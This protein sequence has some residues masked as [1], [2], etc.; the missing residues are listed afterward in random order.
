MRKG[1]K[2]LGVTL[3]AAALLSVSLIVIAQESVA[4]SPQTLNLDQFAGSEITVHAAI[5]YDAAA[6]VTLASED[7]GT[8]DA[9]VTFADDRGDLVAKFSLEDVKE[10]V[11][12][13][14]NTLA[15]LVDGRD[16]GSDTI[17]VILGGKQKG[18]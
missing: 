5:D 1:L 9:V 7:G 6:V 13:G 4:I 16:I 10:I 15:L 17:R 3:T 2:T 12:E 14:N 18:K 8:I 11:D